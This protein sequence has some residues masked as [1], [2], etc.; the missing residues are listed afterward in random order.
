[1]VVSHD[2]RK[3]SLARGILEELSLVPNL[4][5]ALA[6]FWNERSPEVDLAPIVRRCVEPIEPGAFLVVKSIIATACVV[7]TNIE[8]LVSEH[9][10]TTIFIFAPLI[11]KGAEERLMAEFETT[12]S[13]R[14]VI[15][16]FAQDDDSDGE[17]VRPGIGGQ[18]YERLGLGSGETKNRCTPSLVRE[19]RERFQPTAG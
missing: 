10:P 19:R 14:F 7:R 16:W 17:N 15:D 12:I 18:V 3:Q 6:C 9:Q 8:E 13:D 4:E 5:V 2:T 1:M 11:L